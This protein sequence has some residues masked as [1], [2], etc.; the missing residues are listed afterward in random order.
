SLLA[1]LEG[2]SAG[3]AKVTL[4]LGKQLE[5]LPGTEEAMRKGLLSRAKATELAAAA[6]FDPA[7]EP[8]LLSG[9]ED[10]PLAQVKERCHRSRAT[11]A[12]ADPLATIKRIRAERYFSSWTDPDGAFCFKGRDTADRGAKILTRM[13]QVTNALRKARRTGDQPPEPE[14]AHRADAFFAL[15]TQR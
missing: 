15:V 2:I 4:D 9:A 1:A 5:E 11:S 7:R 8:A 6:T 13:N 10:E 12:G 3:Q 14:A